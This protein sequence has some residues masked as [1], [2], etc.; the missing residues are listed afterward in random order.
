MS[1]ITRRRLLQSSAALAV[2]PGM[3]SWGASPA[4]AGPYDDAVLVEGEPP[5]PEAGSFTV[6][7]L[8]DTQFY[9]ETYPD[10][11]LAQTQW[12]VDNRESRN[13][14]CVLHLGDI[15]NRNTP[16][17]WENATRALE[18][19][20]GKLP[21]FLSPGNHDY[22]AG[23]R[24]TDRTTLMSEYLP[25]S[26][27][28]DLPTYGG[29]YDKEPERI[30]N[31]WHTFEAGGQKFLVLG[32][33]FGPRADVI[34]WANEVVA[35][36]PDH[37]AILITHAYMYYDDTRYDWHA[38]GT[39]QRW[40]PHSYGVAK[41]TEDDVNDGEE[42]WTKLVSKQENFLMTLNGHVLFDGLGRTTTPTPAGRQVPQMLVNF[43]MKPNGG[44]G[45]LRLMEFRAD[46]NS[47]QTYDYSP[48]LGQRNESPKNQFQFNYA[49]PQGVA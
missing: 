43:Q 25:V 1:R 44:D 46:G 22:S 12:I 18:Q 39:E 8:P 28:K 19:L 47:V 17:E 5:K 9:S 30:E 42:L 24:A 20:D 6:A 13:I 32:L 34:R 37:G 15:T 27:F 14:A 35:K 7:V 21:Y 11:F 31:C 36:H 49:K 26:K 38:K 3:L 41:A 4:W 10:Q 45:W 23:G 48:T 2:A 40:N 33:E 16:R 29:T